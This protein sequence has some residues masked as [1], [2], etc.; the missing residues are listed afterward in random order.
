VRHQ[1]STAFTRP[2]LR[3]V[4]IT[5]YWLDSAQAPR[6]CE[7]LTQDTVTDLAVVGGGYT[8]LWTA[9]LAKERDPQRDVVL[10]E[11]REVG[12]A[13]SGRNGGFCSASLTHGL[14][15]GLERFADEMPV[16]ERLGRENLD[17]IEKTVQGQQG[18]SIDCAWERTGE[19]T[20]ATAQWQLD[21]LAELPALAA[22]FGGHLDLLDREQVQARVHSPTYLG[23]VLDAD[24]VAMVDPARLAWGLR[25]ACLR[26]GV[27]IFEG[28]SVHR[29]RRASTNGVE[30]QTTYGV[31]SAQQVA[32]GTGALSALLRR[33]GSF[34]APVWDYAMV[35][36]P[37]S[38]EQLASIGWADRHGIGDA[39]N[40]FHYYRRTDDNRIL[41][42]GYDAV[43]RLGGSTDERHVRDADTFERLSDHFFTTF[44]QL[45]GLRF[46][47]A[48]GGVIDTCSRF[49]AF[50]GQALGG[51]LAYSAGYTGLGV[52]AS[53]FGA[54]VMLDLLDGQP[55][56]LTSLQM[57]R[58]KPIPFPPEPV[59]WAG[60]ELTR[61][62]IARADA[63]GG[64]RGPWL[65]TLDRLGLGFDS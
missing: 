61:R 9:L 35:T 60:I 50:W 13:A 44:P 11:S 43:Y 51:R 48:W 54:Q 55:T 49:C 53:R 6:P 37:L 36:E 20:V 17:A 3:D 25:A 62:A 29:L 18:H 64:R 38:A 63:N 27:R 33:I 47:H 14:R 2:S 24:G 16:L 65:R 56:E 1:R 32:L 4:R 8:G 28:T 22:R 40:M 31:V 39:G 21:E 46:T 59:R 10:L 5:P 57:V 7:A 34:V 19:L 30:L 12:W 15:N 42:G 45:E 41:W 52:G 58:S 26:L 23:G